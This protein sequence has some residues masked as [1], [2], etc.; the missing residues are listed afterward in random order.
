M[1]R[2]TITKDYETCE[3]CKNQKTCMYYTKYTTYCG[4]YEKNEKKIKEDKSNGN[5]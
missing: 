3:F 5:T 1:A 2:K 4:R